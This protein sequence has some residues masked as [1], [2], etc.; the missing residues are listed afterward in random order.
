MSIFHPLLLLIFQFLRSS[1][2]L[3]G[4]SNFCLVS[5]SSFLLLFR[6]NQFSRGN[7]IFFSINRDSSFSS[8]SSF[9][10]NSSFKIE[11][12]EFPSPFVFSSLLL[13]FLRPSTET[14]F[15]N[16]PRLYPFMRKITRKSRDNNLEISDV[17]ARNYF[18]KGYCETDFLI[19]LAF[20]ALSSLL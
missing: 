16:A 14:H 7:G 11:E 15:R 2:K 3:D 4:I 9:L 13:A 18:A 17:D 12:V 8:F 10:K 5:F 1:R 20:L 19:L 6:L